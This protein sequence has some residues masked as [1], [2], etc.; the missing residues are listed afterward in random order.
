MYLWSY[1]KIKCCIPINHLNW[2]CGCTLLV[3]M[4]EPYWDCFSAKVSNLHDELHVSV[5][6]LKLVIL[7]SLHWWGLTRPNYEELIIMQFTL[8]CVLHFRNGEP[9]SME[10]FNFE[11]CITDEHGDW[12]SFHSAQFRFSFVIDDTQDFKFCFFCSYR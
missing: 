10:A 7:T 11:V 1:Y 8:N 5:F 9:D 3:V 4:N 2:S 6:H 12:H